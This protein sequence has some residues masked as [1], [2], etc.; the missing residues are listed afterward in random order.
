MLVTNVATPFLNVAVPKMVEPPSVKTTV[1]VGSGVSGVAVND[2]VTFIV[3]DWPT[4]EVSGVMLKLM[5]MDVRSLAS[6]L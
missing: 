1:P 4:T 2:T 3:T 5:G 6:T